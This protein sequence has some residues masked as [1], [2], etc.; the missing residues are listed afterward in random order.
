M[1]SASAEGFGN[2]SNPKLQR[3]TVV[4]ILKELKLAADTRL[5]RDAIPQPKS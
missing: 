4:S 2:Q 5:R 1:A 3:Q